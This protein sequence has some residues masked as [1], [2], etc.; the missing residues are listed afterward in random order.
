[1]QLILKNSGL[2]KI[3]KIYIGVGDSEIFDFKIKEL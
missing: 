2:E 1:M 3:N